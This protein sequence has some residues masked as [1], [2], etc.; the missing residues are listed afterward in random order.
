MQN[1]NE[2]DNGTEFCNFGS[3]TLFEDILKTQWII[4]L[5]RHNSSFISCGGAL[6]E[7]IRS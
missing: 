1:E 4:L 6:K 7:W 3:N 5:P 2:L